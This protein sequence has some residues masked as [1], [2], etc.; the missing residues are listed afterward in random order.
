MEELYD[1][2]LD[3]VETRF[4]AETRER[5][6]GWLRSVR[7]TQGHLAIML[8]E[9]ALS[10]SCMGQQHLTLVGFTPDGEPVVTPDLPKYDVSYRP[11]SYWTRAG[12]GV[13]AGSSSPTGKRPAVRRRPLLDLGREFLPTR[14]PEEV[15]IALIALASVTGDVISIRARRSGKRIVYGIVDEYGTNFRFSPKQSTQPL[16]LGELIAMIDY[17]TGHLDGARGLTSAYRDY[18][19]DGCDAERLLDFV[20]VTSDFYPE[21]QRYYVDEARAWL[22]RVKAKRRECNQR[23]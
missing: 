4:D 9:M 5:F 3:M 7:P 17:A 23:S 11:A 21:L 19:L 22:A 20:T 6:A 16:S 10:G 13:D 12:D 15:E 1:L 18:N 2:V 14:E 8:T